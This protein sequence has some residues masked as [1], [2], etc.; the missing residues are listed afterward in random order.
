MMIMVMV[1]HDEPLILMLIGAMGVAITGATGANGTTG[2]LGPTG[3]TGQDGHVIR[4][5]LGALNDTTDQS[6]YET[7]GMHSPS[8]D[9]FSDP[10]RLYFVV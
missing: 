9:Q 4:P 7:Y 5:T 3:A 1:T 2:A 6:F 8:F 10:S